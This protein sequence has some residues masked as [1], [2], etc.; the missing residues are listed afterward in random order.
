MGYALISVRIHSFIHSLTL[1][2]PT[3]QGHTN[4]LLLFMNT[5][6]ECQMSY[7]RVLYNIQA[8]YWANN[9]DSLK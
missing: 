1:P 5:L 3:L 9:T 4:V 2:Y 7:N 6:A 8:G